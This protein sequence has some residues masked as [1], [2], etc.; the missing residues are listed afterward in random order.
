VKSNLYDMSKQRKR[1]SSICIRLIGPEKITKKA[2]TKYLAKDA[3]GA[4]C[5]QCEQCSPFSVSIPANV[6]RHMDSVHSDLIQHYREAE[7]RNKIK[8]RFGLSEATRKDGICFR[9]EVFVATVNLV[10]LFKFETIY[11]EVR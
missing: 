4:Y 2:K 5:T 10:D 7:E 1:E 11:G 9:P 8:G 6:S 3:V